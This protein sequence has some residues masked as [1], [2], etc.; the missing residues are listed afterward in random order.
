MPDNVMHTSRTVLQVNYVFIKH[1]RY[2]N[3]WLL[4]PVYAYVLVWTIRLF[5]ISILWIIDILGA[6]SNFIQQLLPQRSYLF[7]INKW[8]FN[9]RLYIDRGAS[10]TNLVH[11]FDDLYVAFF[12]IIIVSLH[13][14]SSTLYIRSKK[15]FS[16]YSIYTYILLWKR[17]VFT[18]LYVHNMMFY[19]QKIVM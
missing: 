3:Y 10:S 9:E 1:P 16:Y 2:K 18:C 17:L 6:R 14:L 8:Q 5:I 19:V 15:P 7:H 12:G 11:P 4:Q 13:C